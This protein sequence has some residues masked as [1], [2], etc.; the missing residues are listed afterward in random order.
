MSVW[1]FQAAVGGYVKANS[2]E[3]ETAIT[4]S[5]AQELAKLVDEPPLWH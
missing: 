3:D 2:P 1:E 5:E 4:G